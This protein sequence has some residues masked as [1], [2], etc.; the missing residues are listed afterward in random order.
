V[1]T[2]ALDLVWAVWVGVAAAILLF[3]YRVSRSI[4]RR[5]Y[6]GDAV[7]SKRMLDRRLTEFLAE[8]GP[9]IVVFELESPIFF[10]TAEKL[11]RQVEAD[12]RNDTT[13]VILDLRR[14]NE[15]DTTGA[16][17]LVQLAGRLRA[18]G[19]Q[20]LLSHLEDNPLAVTPPPDPP[21]PPTPEAPSPPSA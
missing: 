1:V 8:A 19:T 6:R 3:L 14:V 13:F 2:I 12:V 18:A 11:A 7:R 4:V 15:L 10:G 17:V 9:R 5:T 16:A 20:L 21:L